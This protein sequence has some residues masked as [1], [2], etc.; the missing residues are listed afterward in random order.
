ME[1][2]FLTTKPVFEKFLGAPNIEFEFRL[3]KIVPGTAGTT[4]FDTNI[5]KDSFEKILQG[6][7]QYKGWESTKTTSDTVYSS[8]PI[9][10]T[11]DDDTE[12]SVQI[13]K[14]KLFKQ[15]HFI[16]GKPFD[17]RFSVS[18]ETPVNLPDHEYTQARQRRRESFVRKN[19]R[20]D[21]TVV[22]GN[23]MDMD[24]E[25]METYQVELEIIDP[26]KVGDQLYNIIHKIHNVLELV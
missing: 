7:K 8:G 12:N 24:S 22:S 6:L 11:I 9:R 3:G 16:P 1:A 20:I 5:G 17:V 18:S 14:K 4:S 13:S 2:V 25:D 10:L 19:V 26:S 23:P 15:D 21:M